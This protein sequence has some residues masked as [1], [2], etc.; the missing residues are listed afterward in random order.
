MTFTFTVVQVEEKKIAGI[1]VETNM[2]NAT[3]DCP[4]LWGQFMLVM[5]TLMKNP[6]VVQ[7]APSY[8]V[9]ECID[10]DRF[11]YWAALQVNSVEDLPADL[12]TMT[13]GSGLHVKCTVPSLQQLGEGYAALNAWMI[14]QNKYAYN[15]QGAAFE[16]YK[17]GWQM[18]DS[19]DIYVAIV[20]K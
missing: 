20:E 15:I 11:V 12:K 6:V 19:V 4:R 17:Q 13:I 14:A 9:S 18:T 5:G 16:E 7:G 2:A 3:T 8:G 10:G 1:N